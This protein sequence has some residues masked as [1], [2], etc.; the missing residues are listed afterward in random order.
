MAKTIEEQ[1]AAFEFY[2]IYLESNLSHQALREKIHTDLKPHNDDD[3]DH[4]LADETTPLLEKIGTQAATAQTIKQIAQ[5]ISQI[6]QNIDQVNILWWVNLRKIINTLTGGWFFYLGFDVNA[7]NMAMLNKKTTILDA[8][9]KIQ[10]ACYI[11]PDLQTNQAWIAGD[12]SLAGDQMAI[13]QNQAPALST[14]DPAVKLHPVDSTTAD[15]ATHIQTTTNSETLNTTQANIIDNATDLKARERAILEA[16]EAVMPPTPTDTTTS[17]AP[18]ATQQRPSAQDLSKLRASYN[19]YSLEQLIARKQTID[20]YLGPCLEINEQLTYMQTLTADISAQLKGLSQVHPL[21]PELSA[22]IKNNHAAIQTQLLLISQHKLAVLDALQ[23]NLLTKIESNKAALAEK[24][25]EFNQLS[26]QPGMHN[27]TRTQYIETL[28]MLV[29]Q[30]EHDNNLYAENLAELSTMQSMSLYGKDDQEKQAISKFFNRINILLQQNTAVNIPQHQRKDWE[31]IKTLWKYVNKSSDVVWHFRLNSA[32]RL[33]KTLRTSATTEPVNPVSET[34]LALVTNIPKT[35]PYKLLELKSAIETY[36]AVPWPKPYQEISRIATQALAC[37]ADEDS[38]DHA[39]FTQLAQLKASDSPQNMLAKLT[40]LMQQPT[41]YTF[42]LQHIAAKLV[43]WQQDQRKKEIRTII[44]AQAP[45]PTVAQLTTDTD[46]TAQLAACQKNI[47]HAA[48]LAQEYL[49]YAN[50]EENLTEICQKLVTIS[51]SPQEEL[52][53]NLEALM[54]LWNTYQRSPK[55]KADI[56]MVFDPLPTLMTQWRTLSMRQEELPQQSSAPPDSS[57]KFG[58]A[59]TQ[60]VPDP[61]NIA[62][63]V[64][65]ATQKT[66]SGA[67]QIAAEQTQKSA[68]YVTENFESGVKEFAG[69]AKKLMGVT[70]FK[71][72]AKSDEQN[73]RTKQNNHPMIPKRRD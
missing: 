7:S 43:A 51:T 4:T 20:A 62:M 22:P 34:L 5:D 1:N 73:T 23:T 17:A 61:V 48:G 65:S 68:R 35:K 3:D 26:Q 58:S 36:T 6:K 47:T 25:L 31:S 12:A 28:M 8:L 19:T 39:I 24:L 44:H 54:S 33:E 55:P 30:L 10:L 41:D 50:S 67:V 57:T 27:S 46:I 38:A 60:V 29:V 72:P 49:G 71:Q 52:Y 45:S 32:A 15:A 16:L 69:M 37:I 13:L 9:L 18:I 11:E 14:R 21:S 59:T 56:A 70:F 40:P 64:A 66:V 2:I 42:A 63:G 53:E